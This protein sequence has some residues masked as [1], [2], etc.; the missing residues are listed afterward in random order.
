MF[1]IMPLEFFNQRH[2]AEGK[3]ISQ[4]FDDLQ[5]TSLLGVS[6]SVTQLDAILYCPFHHA[7][8]NAA[9]KDHV[10]K[11]RQ[12]I[13]Q[14]GLQ[15]NPLSGSPNCAHVILFILLVCWMK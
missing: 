3:N 6:V 7:F 15:L 9:F 14:Y 12:D 10:I 5:Y 13:L 4:L 8:S 11:L 1:K 2:Q